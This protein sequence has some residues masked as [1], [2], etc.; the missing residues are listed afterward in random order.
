MASANSNPIL[1]ASPAS[2]SPT[3][4]ASA[5]RALT[6]NTWASIFPATRP[7]SG[8]VASRSLT[9][10]RIRGQ[11]TLKGGSAAPQ[12]PAPTPA[13]VYVPPYDYTP[14]AL[15]RTAGLGYTATPTNDA[16]Y[17]NNDAGYAIVQ[18]PKQTMILDSYSGAR[19]GAA[20]RLPPANP[21]LGGNA[22]GRNAITPNA[23]P[24]GN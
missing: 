18:D 14:G 3:A 9:S 11:R 16:H 5:L 10:G 12:P 8:G 6:A 17:A 2:F 22:S 24:S 19:V 20:D 13:P 15:I 1:S 21:A 4:R 23:A 7:L